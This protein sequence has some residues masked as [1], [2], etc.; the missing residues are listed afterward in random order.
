MFLGFLSLEEA[1]PQEQFWIVLYVLE[2]SISAFEAYFWNKLFYFQKIVKVLFMSV[3]ILIQ[4]GDFFIWRLVFCTCK[5]NL[6]ILF[7]EIAT[8]ISHSLRWAFISLWGALKDKSQ[9]FIWFVCILIRTIGMQN[10]GHIE[11]QMNLSRIKFLIGYNFKIRKQTNSQPSFYFLILNK[12]KNF[13]I[14]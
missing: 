14:F 4:E 9:A 12:E 2:K 8:A 13:L 11:K 5:T 3:S 6:I 7:S 10:K 1:H